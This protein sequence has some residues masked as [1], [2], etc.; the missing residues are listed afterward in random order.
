MELRI[1][2]QGVYETRSENPVFQQCALRFAMEISRGSLLFTC[3]TY[4]EL[5]EI[6]SDETEKHS[7]GE[8]P[9][10]TMDRFIPLNGEI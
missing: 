10:R 9:P 4:N 6:G 2:F 7:L 8:H 1:R 3:P 5:F